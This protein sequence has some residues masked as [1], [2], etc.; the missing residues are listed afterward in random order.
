MKK[1]TVFLFCVVLLFSCNE[2]KPLECTKSVANIS[3]PY[4]VTAY[5]YK[6]TP[7]S[8]E[9][10]YYPI[11]FPDACDRDDIYTFKTNGTYEMKDAGLVCSPPDD[12]TGVW[13]YDGNAMTIDGYPAAL[14]SFD[15]KT[16]IISTA[17]INI[18]GDKL[19]ITMI[20]Q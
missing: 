13:T 14:E 1:T 17:D 10:D 7:T 6:Q 15:C 4:R 16:L 18:A 11:I 3:G 2:K 19:K 20:K 9:E 5:G 8:P 12:E